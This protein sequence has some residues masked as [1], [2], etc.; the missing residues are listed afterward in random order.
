MLL[1]NSRSSFLTMYFCVWYSKVPSG[2]FNV[3]MENRHFVD[4]FPTKTSIYKGFSMAMSNNQ[5]VISPKS[6]CFFKRMFPS[7]KNHPAGNP[8]RPPRQPPAYSLRAKAAR[9]RSRREVVWEEVNVVCTQPAKGPFS[10]AKMRKWWKHMCIDVKIDS[11]WF[12][13]KP[14]ELS[15]TIWL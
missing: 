13:H 5:R 9:P 1:S 15:W 7:K 6:S 14:L 8:L 2:L 4:D 12:S 11:P 3:A 10:R